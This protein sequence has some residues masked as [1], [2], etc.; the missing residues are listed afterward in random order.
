MDLNPVNFIN[1][2]INRAKKERPI[3]FYLE[4]Y[5]YFKT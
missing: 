3:E 2:I 4:Q 5:N 1:Q